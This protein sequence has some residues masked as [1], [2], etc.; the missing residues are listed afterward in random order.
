MN[1]TSYIANRPKMAPEGTG[2]SG[3]IFFGESLGS[4]EAKD[5]LPFRPQADAG[6][7]LM[8]ALRRV[9]VERETLKLTNLVWYQPPGNKLSGM[10][11]EFDAIRG[12]RADNDRL[13]EEMKPRAILALGGLAFRELSGLKGNKTNISLTRGFIVDS[14]W[15]PGIPVIGTFH[16]SA[17]HRGSKGKNSEGVKTETPGGG[18]IGPNLLGVL[19]RDIKLALDVAKNGRPARPEFREWK[20]GASLEDWE[21]L[22]RDTKSRP[23]WILSYDFETWNTFETDDEGEMKISSSSEPT[24]FQLSIR[25]GHALVSPWT[26]S[27]REVVGKLMS[28]PNP[29][30]DW[31]GRKFDRPLLRDLGIRMDIGTWHDGMDMWHHA[32]PD[33]QRGLQFA[34]S[35]A[36]PEAGPWKHLAFLEPLRYGAFDVDMPLRVFQYLTTSMGGKVHPESGKSLL[37][38]YNTQVAE[39]SPVLDRMSE[40]GIPV[41]NEIRIALGEE[42]DSTLETISADVTALAPWQV[43]PIHPKRGYKKNPKYLPNPFDSDALESYY[44]TR[45]MVENEEFI[46]KHFGSGSR[47]GTQEFARWAKLLPFNPGSSDQVMEYLKFK[48]YEVP[49][50]PKTGNSTTDELALRKVL[51]RHPDSL[52]LRVLDYREIAKAKSAYVNG[53]EPATD[54]RVHPFFGFRPATGQISSEKPNA[55]NFVKHSSLARKM[56][57]MIEARPGHRFVS[58]DYKSF[59]VLTTGFEAR[60]SSYMRLARLDMH[61]FFALTGLLKLE[62]PEKLLELPD[63]ELSQKLKWYRKNPRIFP[64]YACTAHPG[65]M[66]FSEIR[67]ERAKRAILGIGF[68][69]TGRGLF[70]RNPDSFSNVKD[71]EDT[72]KRLNEVFPRPEQWRKEV[73]LEGD[74]YGFL[75]TRYGYIRWFWDVFHRQFLSENYSPREGEKII[76]DSRG[77]RWKISPGDDHEAVVAYRPANDAFGIKRAVMVK[78]GREGLDEKYQFIDEIHDDLIFEPSNEVFDEM[79][80]RVKSMM[81]ERSRV[82]SDPLVAPA[83]LFCEV[84]VKMGWNWDSREIDNEKGMREIKI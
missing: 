61:S 65:G 64:A 41:N 38:G 25:P 75:M 73:R 51:G 12:S 68:G 50:H 70:K 83:G 34:A 53:W 66:T 14:E 80:P 19:V 40:R 58:F 17:L 32:Q 72:I 36:C 60:D 77:A 46:F 39:L 55:Q 56:R 3:V 59:H 27:L 49:K 33:I 44:D 24:Q 67:D 37:W 30:L 6:S 62:S 57:R 71:A 79:V 42:F 13:V 63:E 81:E 47:N 26:S 5:R 4:H 15:Y 76:E 21:M 8:R 48:R 45:R 82:L 23:E 2:S 28:L 16:P 10:P 29:K 84:E 7:M 78:L 18:T 52:L 11:Y 35:F 31:N 69:Q 9:P 74:K 20:L 54:G 22:L 1:W 43:R